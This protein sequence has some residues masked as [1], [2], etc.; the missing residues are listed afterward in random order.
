MMADKAVVWITHQLDLLPSCDLVAIVEGGVFSYFG[1]Y[2]PAVVDPMS[3]S[4][5]EVCA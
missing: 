3:E 5:H 1:P 4:Q 2:D